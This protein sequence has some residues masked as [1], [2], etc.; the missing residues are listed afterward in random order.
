MWTHGEVNFQLAD[1][2]SKRS[3][4]VLQV[5]HPPLFSWIC[6]QSCTSQDHDPNLGDSKLRFKD[7]SNPYESRRR[8][9]TSCWF[10][11]V[12]KPHFGWAHDHILLPILRCKAFKLYICHIFQCGKQTSKSYLFQTSFWRKKTVPRGLCGEVRSVRNKWKTSKKNGHWRQKV[13]REACRRRR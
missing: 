3:P 8:C 6:N 10:P 9:Q 5:E 2:A 12:R 4:H 11:Q 13:S 7:P 1:P